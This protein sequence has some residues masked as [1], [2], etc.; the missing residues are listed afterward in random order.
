[1]IYCIY[2]V[3]LL[4]SIHKTSNHH[5]FDAQIIEKKYKSFPQPQ[6]LESSRYAVYKSYKT[7][8]LNVT[9]SSTINTKQAETL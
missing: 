5:L 4:M 2:Y 7:A 9:S 8:H 3:A 1:M 6:L